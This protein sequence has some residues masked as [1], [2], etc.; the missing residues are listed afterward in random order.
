MQPKAGDLH[1]LAVCFSFVFVSFLFCVVTNYLLQRLLGLFWT[2]LVLSTSLCLAKPGDST[3]SVGHYVEFIEGNLPVIVLV[4]HGGLL[5]P[6]DMA[7]RVGLPESEV[8]SV[9]FGFVGFVGTLVLT[10][11]F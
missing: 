8:G 5:R 6:F 11:V 1:R 4:P 2:S 10:I 9:P 7:D 3:F